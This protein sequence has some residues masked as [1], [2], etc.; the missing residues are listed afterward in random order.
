MQLWRDMHTLNIILKDRQR[1]FSTFI[2]ILILDN[3]L[4]NSNQSCGIIDLS[5][6]DAKKKLAKIKFAYDNLP[7]EIREK[8]QLTTDNKELLEWNNGSSVAVGTSHRGGTCQILHISEFGKIA[9]RRPDRAREIR[10]GAL[11]TVAPGCYVFI[12][13]T[14]E[15]KGGEFFDYVQEAR[16]LQDEG[17]RL[18]DLDFNLHFFAAWHGDENK[19]PAEYVQHYTQKQLDYF[20]KV[21]VEN[22]I[23]LS[24]EFRAWYVKKKAQQKDDM[25][26]EYPNTI[27]EAFESSVDGS[28]Y[29]KKIIAARKAGRITKVPYEESLHTIT[30]WDLGMNDAM[31][32]WF[33]QA[34]GLEYRLIDYYEN[35]G[36]GFPHYAQVL[37]DKGYFYSAHLM[38]HDVNVRELGTGRSRIEA[39][40]ALG[41]KPVERVPRA[42][43]AEEVNADIDCVRSFLNS[44]WIDKE[45]CSRGI[46]CLEAYRKDWNERLG[47][48]NNSPRKDWSGHGADALRTFAKGIK[49]LGGLDFLNYNNQDMNLSSH[50]FYY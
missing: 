40:E 31:S 22:S 12:E 49:I 28:Y 8:L 25:V 42:R 36:E 24:P 19:L 9:A 45:K 2:A 17:D 23:T 30:A 48:F 29:S 47:V 35:S 46:E 4:F 34:N 3:C 10:T 11:N 7:E 50:D 26:R 39:A 38:P 14:G 37:K 13:S 43:G 16:K 44:C 5:L 21:E 41:I 32:I 27:D 1:G 6:P 15:G 20:E 18:T 33:I